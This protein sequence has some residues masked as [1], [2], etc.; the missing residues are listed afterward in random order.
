MQL[1][2]NFK[3]EE[4]GEVKNGYQLKLIEILATELQ[5]VRDWVNKNC[6]EFALNSKKDITMTITSGIRTSEDFMR[7]KSKGYNPSET[8]DH[9]CGI[10]VN[11]SPTLGAADIRFGNFNGNYK[12]LY[13]KLVAAHEFYF[14]FGQMILEYN[15]STKCYWI[16]FGNDPKLIFM[17]GT[18]ATIARKRFLISNDNGKSYQEYNV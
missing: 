4:F 18:A 12:E 17:P 8:S 13:K 7:L 5:K 15:P 2:K 9:L 10:S 6:K 16:H 14:T 1:T 11:G 3:S